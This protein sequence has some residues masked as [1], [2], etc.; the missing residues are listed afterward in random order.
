[1]LEYFKRFFI[2]VRKLG[3]EAEIAKK[4]D[5]LT[6]KATSEKSKK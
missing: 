4:R 1:M 6:D 3:K 2:V 5:E